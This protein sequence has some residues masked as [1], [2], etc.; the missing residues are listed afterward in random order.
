[1]P[2]HSAHEPSKPEAQAKVCGG[3]PSLAL[4]ASMHTLLASSCAVSQNK[5]AAWRPMRPVSVQLFN[6]PRLP[7]EPTKQGRIL[8]SFE[9][10]Q[11]GEKTITSGDRVAVAIDDLSAGGLCLT[12]DENRR[13]QSGQDQKAA[14]RL[15]FLSQKKP[16][17]K[18]ETSFL[19]PVEDRDPDRQNPPDDWM[20]VFSSSLDDRGDSFTLDSAV[21]AGPVPE[22]S[23][24]ES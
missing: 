15:L 9:F 5:Q 12:R 20:P 10:H 22:T 11:A 16:N 2:T 4:Q 18:S 14:H 6:V 8:A 23:I 1:M 3:T 21:L 19:P 24:T 7:T 17:R 13:R